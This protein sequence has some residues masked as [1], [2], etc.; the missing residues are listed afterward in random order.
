VWQWDLIGDAFGETRPNTNP[1][2]TGDFVLDLRFPGQ[3]YDSESGTRYSYFRDYEPGTGRY[4]QSDP[5]GLS[6]GVATFGYVSGNPVGLM[7][8]FGLSACMVYWPYYPIV[9]PGTQVSV[10]A[11]HAGVL[12]YDSEGNTRYYEYGRYES[13]HGNTPRQS[14]SDFEMENGRPLKTPGAR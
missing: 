1:Y 13:S 8:P 5:I 14:V 11:I 7:D 2:R 12:T 3:I 4:V 6:G 10:P 9:V